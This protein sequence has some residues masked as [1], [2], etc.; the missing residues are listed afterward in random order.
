MLALTAQVFT[1][2]PFAAESQSD[3]MLAGLIQRHYY[4]TA[5]DY[6]ETVRNSCR[7]SDTE[8]KLVDYKIATVHF[9]AIASG[10]NP[11]GADIHLTESKKFLR[12]FLNDNLE[13]LN[14]SRDETKYIFDA[15]SLLGK[16][17]FE[18][19][20][21]Y[22]NHA[23]LPNTNPTQKE[24]LLQLARERAEEAIIT[25]QVAEKIAYDAAKELQ[26]DPTVKSDADKLALR[27]A[28]YTNLVET[29]YRIALAIAEQARCFDPTSKEYRT[30]LLDA[31][32]RFRDITVKYKNFG[33]SFDAKLH[34]AK[35]RRD[36]GNL[37][38]TRALLQELAVLPTSNPIF[39]PILN[40]TLEM[41][42]E[43][44]LREPLTEN[45]NDSV[46]RIEN[47]LKTTP[48]PEQKNT[49][50]A[51]INF[52]AAKTYLLIA[53]SQKTT[54]PPQTAQADKTQRTAAALLANIPN[55]S[56][57]SAEAKKLSASF[58]ENF[59]TENKSH[60]TATNG[61]TSNNTDADA[62]ENDT[63][64]ALRLKIAKEDLHL[65]NY[66]NAV[67]VGEFLAKHY[68]GTSD[69]LRGAELA[70]QG[71]RQL[72]AEAVNTDNKDTYENNLANLSWLQ[73]R[74]LDLSDLI[75][76]HWRQLPIFNESETLLHDIQNAIEFSDSTSGA[77]A[78]KNSNAAEHEVQQKQDAQK[79][80]SQAV[81]L[82]NEGNPA[83]SLKILTE[84]LHESENRL[85]VQL[86]AAKTLQTLGE[87]DEKYYEL[88]IT[89]DAIKPNGQPLIWGWNRLISKT[90]SAPDRFK[91]IY[92]E[93]NLNKIT[94]RILLADKLTGKAAADMKAGA[95][96]DLRR[97][98]KLRPD[99]GGPDFAEKF[100]LLREEIS[101]KE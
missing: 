9:D 88:A 18:E 84:L 69:G 90:A 77:A 56:E 71:I 1:D 55:G 8:K 98:E 95:E 14:A 48:Q 19:A 81:T 58:D 31:A 41:M 36:L 28:T 11:L 93:S 94:C 50:N 59:L 26:S 45:L 99:L 79:L 70:L 54:K 44:N 68:S 83:E 35:A 30:G 34:E 29:R 16:L 86:E 3:K 64:N 100:K 5:L 78:G 60:D 22:S 2:K 27:E 6:L 7:F 23:N 75:S 12:K 74:A 91:S 10:K 101:R 21:S 92:Y 13:D 53:K 40:S 46:S 15:N 97:L 25:F 89:G 52:L 20:R 85:D 76:S 32:N 39:K 51:R 66:E 38:E 47:W 63:V 49:E 80:F 33:V 24:P 42:L 37:S 72:F 62:D 87:T 82:R 67:V 57:F 96:Q 73:N 17:L 4:D 43:L 65:G 61:T